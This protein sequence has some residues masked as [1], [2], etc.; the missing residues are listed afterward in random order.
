[1]GMEPPYSKG[2]FLHGAFGGKEKGEGGGMGSPKRGWGV[3]GS[4]QLKERFP[5]GPYEKGSQNRNK[6]KE[7]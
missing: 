7:L 2:T 5:W 1:M 3:D 4:G 6:K